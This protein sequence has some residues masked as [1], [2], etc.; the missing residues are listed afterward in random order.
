MGF[1]VIGLF[2]LFTVRGLHIAMNAENTF[3]SLLAI[4]C[5]AMI[6]LQAIIILGGVI[7]MIPLTGITLPLVSY[8]GSSMLVTMVFIG[9]LQ[10]ISVRNARLFELSEAG[11]EE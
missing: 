6:S 9:I 11:E 5:T 2:I 3:F 1:L 4:G 7:K 8:G 10:A